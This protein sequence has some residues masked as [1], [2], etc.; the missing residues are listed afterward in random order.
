MPSKQ[1]H[2]A[3]AIEN[4]KAIEFLCGRLEDFPG[5][6]A[7]IAFY[8]ALHIVEALLAGDPAIGDGHTDD[9]KARNHLLKSTNRYK[10]IWKNYFPLWQASLVACYLRDDDGGVDCE[11]FPR[12]MP[13]EV[14]RR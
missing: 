11:V 6:V 8:K 2:V 12:F 14:V 9:H 7:T 3:A 4:Q 13:P 1:A 10:H 5:R